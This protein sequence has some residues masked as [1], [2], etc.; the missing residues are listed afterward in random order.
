MNSEYY[1]KYLKYKNKYL[2]LRSKNLKSMEGGA[3]SN[4]KLD[5]MHA[6]IQ[7]LN[8]HFVTYTNPHTVSLDMI[9]K[10][11]KYLKDLNERIRAWL[12]G[13]A[14]V[15]FSEFSTA[16]RTTEAEFN[17]I[18]F[19]YLRTCFYVN[20]ATFNK[21]TSYDGIK[22]DMLKAIAFDT[23]KL[24]YP[25]Y[26]INDGMCY[27]W[28]K[29]GGAGI[30]QTP[31]SSKE[32]EIARHLVS[33]NTYL[34]N[35]TPIGTPTA[36]IFKDRCD[37]LKLIH[38]DIRNLLKLTKDWLATNKKTIEDL[39]T[40]LHA[41]L[42]KIQA[43]RFLGDLLNNLIQVN[44]IICSKILL[45]GRDTILLTVDDSN[46]PPQKPLDHKV[47]SKSDI[48]YGNF[49]DLLVELENLLMPNGKKTLV[50]C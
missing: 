27:S 21:R 46:M 45:E 10:L 13:R 43:T 37:F 44:Q 17:I 5:E 11:Y 50:K 47:C 26:N 38:T 16:V 14:G 40:L 1:V 3:D 31:I 29:I 39:K 4:Q 8:K 7:L 19:I 36:V 22:V 24:L 15:T 35:I 28:D 30:P 32:E 9:K 25:T 41:E 6:I 48:T 33:I 12:T 34:T 2:E 18:K 23:Y 20:N 42:K 49:Q